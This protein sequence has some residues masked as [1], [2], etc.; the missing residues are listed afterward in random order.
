MSTVAPEPRRP[1]RI[2]PDQADA[3]AD[4]APRPSQILTGLAQTLDSLGVLVLSMA[5]ASARVERGEADDPML[6]LEEVARELRY[7]VSHVRGKCA[8]GEIKALNDGGW[9]IRR[10]ALKRYEQRRTGTR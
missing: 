8:S 2:S 3:E 10:S 6:T 4:E 5:E 1:S 9:R 7:S